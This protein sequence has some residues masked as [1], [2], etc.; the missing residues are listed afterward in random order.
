QGAVCLDG[1]VY[2]LL[3]IPGL[4]SILLDRARGPARRTDLPRHTLGRL[5]PDVREHDTRSHMRQPLRDRLTQPGAATGNDRHLPI[6]RTHILSPCSDRVS[7]ARHICR[8]R[9]GVT[10][11]SVPAR[12]CALPTAPS[13]LSPACLQRPRHADTIRPGRGAIEAQRTTSVAGCP[14]HFWS[15]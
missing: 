15:M 12:R 7:R 9:D 8:A 2:D 11:T 14:I 3:G 1:E 13:W 4:R 10:A 6:E 5:Q